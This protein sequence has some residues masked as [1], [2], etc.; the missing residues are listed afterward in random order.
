M[1]INKNDAESVDELLQQKWKVITVLGCESKGSNREP[2]FK[3]IL[4]R[5]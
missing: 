3:L 2:I 4:D 1:A 5:I